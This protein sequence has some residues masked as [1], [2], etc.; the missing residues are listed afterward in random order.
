MVASSTAFEEKP[1]LQKLLIKKL[2]K[3]GANPDLQD[4]VCAFV[5]MFDVLALSQVMKM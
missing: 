3:N 2:L 4:A 1:H 5:T